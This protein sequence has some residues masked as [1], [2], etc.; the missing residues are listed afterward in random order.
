[1]GVPLLGDSM[2][3][4]KAVKTQAKLRLCLIGPAGSGKTYSALSIGTGLAKLLG[5]GKVALIDTEHGSA[6]KYAGLF[7][8][9]TL[10]LDSFSAENYMAGIKDAS[11][12]DVLII[13][14][15]SH[16]WSGIGGILDQKNVMDA[17]GGN[18]FMNW[19]KLTP[20]LNRLV[21]TILA[22]D[23][24][25]ICTLRSKMEYV[26]E[27]DDRGKVTIRK[28][29]MQ[30]VMRDGIEYEFDLVGD[31]DQDNNFM[32]SKTRCPELSGQVV[33][34]PN[35]QISK[36]LHAWLTDGSE[37]KAAPEAKASTDAYALLD[38]KGLKWLQKQTTKDGRW[39]KMGN[40][41]NDGESLTV[42]GITIGRVKELMEAS[43]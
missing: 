37:A 12:Y 10:Q 21:E 19:G 22:S 25:I 34:H 9:D 4:T 38:E 36:A 8:F 32:V 40:M 14:S 18:S 1:M 2:A 35:G 16:A 11:G 17:R 15:L 20:V 24:H 26:Q 30:P 28:V 23:T 29:G 13:D 3:F 43:K 33:K 27:K 39:I 5:K 31:M 7:D 42:G 6:S 41:L